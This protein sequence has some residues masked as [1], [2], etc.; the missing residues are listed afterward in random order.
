MV[1]AVIFDLGKVLVD[2]DYTIALTK[3]AGRSRMSLLELGRLVAQ[4]SLM[5]EYETGLMSS[6]DFFKAVCNAC[7]FAGDF[8]EFGTCFGDIFAPIEPMVELHATLRRR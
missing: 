7:G 3:I 5:M 6:E 1:K 8:D 2:F 4:S